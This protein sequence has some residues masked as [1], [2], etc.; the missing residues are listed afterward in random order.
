MTAIVVDSIAVYEQTGQHL[1]RLLSSEGSVKKAVTLAEAL[2]PGQGQETNVEQ[3]CAYTYADAGI[4]LKDS[5][6]MAK[7]LQAFSK[8]DPKTSETASYD[9]ASIQLHLW[10]LAVKQSGLGNSWLSKRSHLHEARRLFDGVADDED[11][12]IELRIKALTDCGNSFDIV[13]RY[14][15]ALDYYE[16]ALKLD[17]YF[18]MAL[19]NR[20]ITLLNVAPLMGGHESHVLSQAASDLD[21]AIKDRERVL[22]CGGQSALA[23]FER[24]RA[25]L[26]G[27]PDLH[28]T[29]SPPS[30]ADPYLDWCLS[31]RLFLNISPECIRANTDILD[32]ISFRSFRLSLT[33]E[34]LHRAS[35]IIDA[36]NSIKQD[37]IA[38]RYLVW[39]ASAPGSPIREHSQRTQS[40]RHSGTPTTTPPG[41]LHQVWGLQ[42]LKVTVD[43]LDTIAA[44]VHLYFHSGQ[45]RDVYFSTFP[46]ADRRKRKK[47]APSFVDALTQPEQNRALIALFDLSA[48][49][50]EQS[51][52]SLRELVQHRH[53]ATHRFMAVHHLGAPASSE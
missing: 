11:A 53:A 29:E 2:V 33:D 39:L 22:R 52:S 5:S 21:F 37:Y 43:T 50:E 31:N 45:V 18:G 27:V 44:F 34:A 32:S 23:T 3:L 28:V 38:A 35:E 30:F 10:Q 41:E 25:K 12:E 15:D 6:L 48:E 46:Y 47:L 49:L 24:W 8:L 20:G 40:A 14:L 4:R 36:F 7:G 42:A 16:H 1:I 9:L 19:G 26:T 51:N 13:G 17:P